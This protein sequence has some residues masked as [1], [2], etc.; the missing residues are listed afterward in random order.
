[1]NLENQIETDNSEFEKL[2]LDDK[3]VNIRKRIRD[4]KS[5]LKNGE[6][7]VVT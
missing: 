5:K 7:K 3:I 4:C 1:M 2:S 6:F